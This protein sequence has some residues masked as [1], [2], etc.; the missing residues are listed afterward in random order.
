MTEADNATAARTAPHPGKTA[1]WIE[2]TRP[3]TLPVSI[4]GVLAGTA[5]ALH[6]GSFRWLPALICLLFAAGAQIAAN[7]AN[8]YYDYKKGLDRRGREGFR[9]GVTEGDIPARAMRNATYLTLLLTSLTGLTLVVWGGWWL[10]AV[11]LAIAVF[12]L[13]YSAGPWPL[14]SH[15]LGDIA[16]FIFFGLIPVFFTAW[17][18]TEDL[19]VWPTALT[20]GSAIGL[21]GVN[22]LIVN[23]YRDA[24]DDRKVGKN[25]TVVRFGRLAM[26]RVYFVNGTIAAILT[27]L[28]LIGTSPLTLLLP[29]AYC[30]LHTFIWT[31]LRTSKGKELNKVLAL[32]AMAM[33]AYAII[34]IPVMLLARTGM[35]G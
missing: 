34:L 20:I 31:K 19:S 2:A 1:S 11:G 8:E 24:D 12:A 18:Q 5:C 28:A 29:F 3:R 25:T 35:H 4:A 27:V 22:V 33:L 13:A 16:V 26:S 21:M 10:I 23:N 14:S 6:H 30:N 17:L 32:T 7:F 15:G 9:R